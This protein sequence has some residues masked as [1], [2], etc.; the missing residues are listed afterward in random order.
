[1]IKTLA[2][3]AMPDCLKTALTTVNW[4]LVHGCADHGLG[5]DA[6]DALALPLCEDV[7]RRPRRD[8][9]HTRA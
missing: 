3:R 8:G 9:Q 4:G 1:M 5:D 2:L 6:V 7:T